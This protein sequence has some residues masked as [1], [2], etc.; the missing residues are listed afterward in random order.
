[1]NI[2][3]K[4]FNDNLVVPCKAHGSDGGLDM[5]LLDELTIRPLETKVVGF[6]VGFKVPSNYVGIFVPRSSIASKGLII[7]TSLLDSGYT[8]ETHLIV[9]NCSGKTYH[10]NKNDRLCSLII[11][12]VE[13]IK[14]NEVQ[15]F[16]ETDRGEKGLGSSGE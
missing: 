3:Y 13:N 15:T 10:F 7:Q 14:L 2:N 11:T 12:K 16:E 6:G 5:F 1:M 9:T 4:K 8:G